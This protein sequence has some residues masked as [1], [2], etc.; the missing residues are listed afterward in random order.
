MD[1][2]NVWFANIDRL[3]DNVLRTVFG[4]LCGLKAYMESMFKEVYE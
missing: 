1:F 2:A 4:A 3:G